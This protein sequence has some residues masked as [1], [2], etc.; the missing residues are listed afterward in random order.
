MK[1]RSLIVAAVAMMPFVVA[2]AQQ[3]PPTAP[4]KPTPATPTTK[5][6]PVTPPVQLFPD[7]IDRDEIRRISEDARMQGQMAAEAGRRAAEDARMAME[8]ARWQM[9]T[10]MKD[11]KLDF[12]HDFKFDFKFDGRTSTSTYRSSRCRR[13]TSISRRCRDRAPRC[14]C[15]VSSSSIRTQP[16][17]RTKSQRRRSDA[18]T[19]RVPRRSSP[20]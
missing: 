16:T 17:R 2:V 15:P 7:L 3:S 10:N 4:V 11:F 19:T 20:R 9:Q 13:R 5:P 12:D 6:T 8:D 18:R 14:G 1:Q